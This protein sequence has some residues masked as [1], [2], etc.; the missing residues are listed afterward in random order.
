MNIEPLPPRLSIGV[1]MPAWLYLNQFGQVVFDAFG[2]WPYLVGSATVTKQWRDVDVR[3]LLDDDQYDAL[4]GSL[5]HTNW[6]AR[7]PKWRALTLAFS[8]L[9]RKMTGLPIDFQIQRR[10]EANLEFPRA[11]QY[12]CPLMMC[13]PMVEPGEETAP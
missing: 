1:G 10:T 12:R 8:E 3:L 6:E 7:N 4:F 13:L 9:G 11:S 2:E 5:K